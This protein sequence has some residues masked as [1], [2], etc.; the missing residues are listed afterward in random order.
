[1]G[2]VQGDKGYD[3]KNHYESCAKDHIVAG[4]LPK[5]NAGTKARGGSARARILW[6]IKQLG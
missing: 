3:A 4:I 5:K 1:V 2:K 6:E